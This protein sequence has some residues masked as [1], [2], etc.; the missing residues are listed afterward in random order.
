M[1]S[2]AQVM[3]GGV[4]IVTAFLF[5]R[6]INNQPILPGTEALAASSNSLN[7]QITDDKQPEVKQPQDSNALQRSLRDRILGERAT[8]R[9]PQKPILP[10]KSEP[11]VTVAKTPFKLPEQ[12]IV[13]P[14]FS[15]LE[16]DP[17]EPKR[18]LAEQNFSQIQPTMPP[19]EKVASW[20]AMPPRMK[21]PPHS[22]IAEPNEHDLIRDY[23]FPG[24]RESRRK[25]PPISK[26]V[27][28]TA[29]K[30][31][32]V[33]R[34]GKF[35]LDRPK[36]NMVPV[37]HRESK[38]TTESDQYISYQTVFGDTLHSISSHFFGKP[39]YYLDIYLANKDQLVNP[40]TVP[41]NST[42]RV[43]VM[44]KLLHRK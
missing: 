37:R 12:E 36:N 3:V 16:L 40:A 24:N 43:P 28:D 17:I 20:P 10:P 35:N 38:L 25:L 4:L 5:G 42:L 14:N 31:D 19:R 13:I 11:E 9:N 32:V 26:P 15:Q 30:K 21:F 8:N 18:K 22:K 29:P 23:S 2:F 39:D 7:R 41:V 27:P 44:D 34:R 6:Y 33:V 1:S